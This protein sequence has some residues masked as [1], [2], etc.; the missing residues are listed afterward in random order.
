MGSRLE[1]MENM[2][3]I[4]KTT[5]GMGK[6]LSFLRPVKNMMVNFAKANDTVREPTTT[7]QAKSY[8]QENGSMTSQTKMPLHENNSLTDLI[9]ITLLVEIFNLVTQIYNIYIF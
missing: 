3:E 8:F 6:E 5:A 7:K 1:K 2:R 4:L 9:L